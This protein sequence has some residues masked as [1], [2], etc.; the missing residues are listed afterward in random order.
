MARLSSA[1][2]SVQLARAARPHAAVPSLDSL[3]A[4][5]SPSHRDLAVA[6][7]MDS[8]TRQLLKD[9]GHPELIQPFREEDIDYDALRCITEDFLKGY[10]PKAGPR[11]K[12]LKRVHDIAE[13]QTE[14][15]E[16]CAQT[17]TSL[18]ESR[19]AAEGNALSFLSASDESEEETRETPEPLPCKRRRIQSNKKCL[20]FAEQKCLDLNINKAIESLDVRDI[21]TNDPLASPVLTVYEGQEPADQPKCLDVAGRKFVL[22][23]ITK[24]IIKLSKELKNIH[25]RVVAGKI[26]A[27]FPTENEETYYVPPKSNSP[28]Q[29]KACGKLVNMYRNLKAKISKQ[30]AGIISPSSSPIPST[31]DLSPYEKLLAA[32]ESVETEQLSAAAT[33]L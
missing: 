17:T 6:A 23:A 21:L 27:L 26:V 28:Q 20:S 29:D 24:H 13:K 25:L 22:Q 1:R 8:K 18:N 31:S 16:V 5:G 14:P 30:Q 4:A 15:T 19:G 2:C 7:G 12:F 32:E 9:W 10:L 33:W 3:R 11:L